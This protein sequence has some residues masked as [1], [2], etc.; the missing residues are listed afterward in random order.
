[1]NN[2]DSNKL[3]DL[4]K[5]WS[6]SHLLDATT[7]HKDEYEQNALELIREEL[8]SRDLNSSS[9]KI[10][11]KALCL[12]QIN[13]DIADLLTVAEDNTVLFDPAS[14]DGFPVELYAFDQDIMISTFLWHEHFGNLDNAIELFIKMLSPKCRMRYEFRGQVLSKEVLEI[15]QD[16]EWYEM[17]PASIF[18]N[19][20]WIKKEIIYKQNNIIKI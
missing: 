9:T 4:Y 19:P 13:D 5:T 20:F 1:M 15:D 6:D 2:L 12:R 8:E 17:T 16:G 18:P 10:D 7:L 14:E 3:R 11:L